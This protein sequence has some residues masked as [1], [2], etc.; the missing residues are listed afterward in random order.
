MISVKKIIIVKIW[1]HLFNVPVFD[2]WKM[3]LFP[4]V[5]SNSQHL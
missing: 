2:G 3:L 1:S 4:K 5:S